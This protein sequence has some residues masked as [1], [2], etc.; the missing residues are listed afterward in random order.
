MPRLKVLQNY[1]DLGLKE[2][3]IAV[4][5]S[6]SVWVVRVGAPSK[7][8][9]LHSQISRLGMWTICFHIAKDYIYIFRT[10]FLGNVIIYIIV[11]ILLYLYYII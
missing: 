9:K 6:E 2:L 3:Y 7:I 11:N 1:N 8:F 4:K 10:I 5:Q